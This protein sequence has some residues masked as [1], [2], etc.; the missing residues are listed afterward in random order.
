MDQTLKQLGE[1]LLGAVPT[2]LL[3]LTLYAVY[4]FVVHKPLQRIL[5]ERRSR[6]QGAVE[7]ARADVSAAE[8]RSREYEDRLREAKLAVF[9]AAEARREAAQQTRAAGVAEARSRAEEQVK[10][11]RAQVDQEVAAARQALQFEGERLANEII[12]VILNP[13]VSGAAS[14]GAPSAA[15]RQS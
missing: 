15:G 6:T 8:A 14:S 3:L 5:E 9:R 12:R 4:H 7:S 13:A 10:A 1:L 11:A 2:V